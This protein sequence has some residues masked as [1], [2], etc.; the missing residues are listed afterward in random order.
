[1]KSLPDELRNFSYLRGFNYTPSYAYN[2]F[3]EWHN[4][5]ASVWEKEVPYAKSFDANHLRI[6]MER[7]PW[8][9]DP[10][11]FLKAVDTAL[12]V[13]NRN[14]MKMMPTIFNGWHHLQ[15][16]MGG[17][18]LQHIADGNWKRF[19]PYI[20]SFVGHFKDD[21]RIVMWDVANE[22]AWE[23]EVGEITIS[24][25]VHMY[26]KVKEIGVSQPVTIPIT[27]TILDTYPD[28]LCF[29]MYGYTQESINAA[30]DKA[31]QI[32]LDHKKPLICNECCPGSFN[33]QERAEIARMSI[34]ALEERGI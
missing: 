32:A 27:E 15:W 20:E 3:E 22:P 31:V 9:A 1:M 5:E 2:Y 16:D 30:C 33:D 14:G 25:L 11:V 21:P 29:H 26:E 10:D 23:S 8:Q 24:F 28:A 19:E 4:F 34:E 7:D 17:T 13:L 6:W 18:Y 12:D